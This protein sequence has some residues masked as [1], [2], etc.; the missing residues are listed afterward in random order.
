[1]TKTDKI[2][3]ILEVMPNVSKIIKFAEDKDIENLYEQARSKFQME[4]IEA[5]Y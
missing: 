2:E 3:Y 4:L 5:C 1:M